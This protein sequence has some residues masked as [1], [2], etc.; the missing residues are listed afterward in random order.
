[1][2]RVPTPSSILQ[3]VIV[4]CAR[5]I[6]DDLI[7]NLWNIQ[8]GQERRTFLECC[9]TTAYVLHFTVR[10][11]WIG[12]GLELELKL[13]LDIELELELLLELWPESELMLDQV[14]ELV[15]VLKL[16]LV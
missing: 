8:I 9:K 1:M 3:S 4:F 14:M 10:N 15:L 7:K 13:E 6:E 16:V 12:I 5:Q 11:M 2:K